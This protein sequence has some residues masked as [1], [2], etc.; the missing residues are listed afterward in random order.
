MFEFVG[1]RTCNTFFQ[2]LSGLILMS[3]TRR[4]KLI[5]GGVLDIEASLTKGQVASTRS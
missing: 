4:H 2:H 5:P 1:G 3:S